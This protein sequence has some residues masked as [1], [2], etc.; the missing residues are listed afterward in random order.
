[1]RRLPN[2][3]SI[4]GRDP[5]KR[6]QPDELRTQLADRLPDYPQLQ[7]Q[8]E[9]QF[10]AEFAADGTSTQIRRDSWRGFRLTSSDK[11]H[12]AQFNRDGLVFSRLQPYEDWE[13]FPEEAQ[14]LWKIFLELAEPSEVQRLGVRFINRIALTELSDVRRYL[15]KLPKCFNGL[16]LPMTG[17]M[18]QSTHD[19]PEHP[20]RI[21]VV[22]TIQPPT[23]PETEGL[24]LILDT[25]VFTTQAISCDDEILQDHW[26]EMRWLKNKVFFSQLKKNAIKKFVGAKK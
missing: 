5:V 13:N 4:G 23:P 10:Q 6:L 15:V 7:N 8:Q 12:I 21:N 26:G 14:R 24:G 19:I 3:S 2:P 17:F 11:L 16:D 22:Q 9:L 20:F 25:D 1:M 18:Y